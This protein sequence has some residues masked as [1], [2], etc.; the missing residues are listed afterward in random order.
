LSSPGVFYTDAEG[1]LQAVL[2]EQR[3]ENEA[4]EQFRDSGLPFQM[5]FE[6]FS[7]I[8]KLIRPYTMPEL[9]GYISE[10]EGVEDKTFFVLGEEEEHRR[11]WLGVEFDEM[12]PELAEAMSLEKPTKDGKI[13]LLVSAVY[14]GSPAAKMGLE[15][16]AVLLRVKCGSD[17]P[18]ID[19]K[20]PPSYDFDF[21]L[22]DLDLPE[23]MEDMVGF[24][25]PQKRPWKS[26]NNYLTKMLGALGEATT[27]ALT[28][29]DSNGKTQ[30]ENYSIEKAPADFESA[31]KYKSNAFGLTA[32]EV[33]Y[34]VRRAIM[35]PTG[36]D[37][38]VVANVENGTPAE[39]A[40]I[41]QYDLV[42]KVNDQP[43]KGLDGFKAML[44]E[45]VA[46]HEAG[47]KPVLRLTVQRLGKTR[48]AD[49]KLD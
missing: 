40:K 48:I 39:V 44:E 33:T 43:V 47:K 11:M 15:A 29:L 38:V 37:P 7:P 4:A 35:V 26:R 36:S 2:L 28:Y 16:G 17:G 45:S 32:K 1:T 42:M 34:E 14:E 20:A 9:A 41:R 46:A 23:G 13:G 22:G 30:T 5:D 31:K 21:D 27:I 25:L 24:E 19:L 6:P 12:T 18:T 10:A 8:G 3:K 49:L